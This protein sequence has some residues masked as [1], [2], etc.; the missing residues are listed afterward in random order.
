MSSR[1]VICTARATVRVISPARCSSI[2]ESAQ[3]APG[4]AAGSSARWSPESTRIPGS[5]S[6][7]VVRRR[8]ARAC[9]FEQRRG[10]QVELPVDDH[11]ADPYRRVVLH[12]Q[13]QPLGCG[14]WRRVGYCAVILGAGLMREPKQLSAGGF[15]CRSD[16]PAR[17]VTGV[18]L[19][20]F[21]IHQLCGRTRLE[22]GGQDDFFAVV[23]FVTEHLVATRGVV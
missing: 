19:S 20:L 17:L 22:L 10:Q 14:G 6:D 8:A 5:G 23:F 12:T 21:P 4:R 13:F 7:V 11:D 15:S 1:P 16:G 18:F 9:L 3:R 2:R